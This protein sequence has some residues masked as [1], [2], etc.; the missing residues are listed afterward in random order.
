MDVAL[1]TM[2]RRAADVKRWLAGPKPAVHTI[3]YGT[4]DE[5]WCDA[6]FRWVA[7]E[8]CEDEIHALICLWSSHLEHI[9]GLELGPSHVELVLS[10]FAANEGYGNAAVFAPIDADRWQK[11]TS[12][13]TR[14]IVDAIS[15]VRMGR[16]RIQGER[17]LVFDGPLDPRN[18][19]TYWGIFVDGRRVADE[20]SFQL[21][22]SMPGEFLEGLAIRS[23]WN[24]QELFVRT[25][26]AYVLFTWSTGA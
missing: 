22:T 2:T 19:S 5:T 14:G 9:E 25:T 8:D 16:R 24:D 21:S 10:T 13:V 12:L 20:R 17:P 18:P 26:E 4:F 7:A 11:E 1:S 6:Q 15:A 3:W 23:E